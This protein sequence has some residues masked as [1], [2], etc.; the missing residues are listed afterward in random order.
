MMWE[1]LMM[2]RLLTSRGSPLPIRSGAGARQQIL[3]KQA[4]KGR[5]G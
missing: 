4:L 5:S 3:S 2:L 1:T